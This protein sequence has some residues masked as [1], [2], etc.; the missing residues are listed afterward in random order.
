MRVDM[1]YKY[2]YIN[3]NV[4]QEASIMERALNLKVNKIIWR[5]NITPFLLLAMQ[6]YRPMNEVTRVAEMETIHGPQHSRLSLLKA[7]IA[8]TVSKCATPSK[9]H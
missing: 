1:K 3:I 2:L 4:H 7:D 5:V 9:R 6:L 8:V